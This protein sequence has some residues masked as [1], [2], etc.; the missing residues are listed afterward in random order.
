ML[1]SIMFIA[2]VAV[3]F[4]WAAER[5]KHVRLK[6][7]FMRRDAVEA[8]RYEQQVVRAADRMMSTPT[9]F[10][11]GLQLGHFRRHI[12][13]PPN[14]LLDAVKYNIARGYLT[15]PRQHGQEAEFYSGH[16]R[17]TDKARLELR[18]VRPEEGPGAS[19]LTPSQGWS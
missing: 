8:K 3:I 15:D 9:L 12:D 5:N 14:V 19:V 10:R 7:E 1:F 2:L 11:A 4:A 18:G 16:Y 13:V 17:M 6:D